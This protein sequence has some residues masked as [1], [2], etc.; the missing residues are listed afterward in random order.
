MKKTSNIPLTILPRSAPTRHTMTSSNIPVYVSKFFRMSASAR[1]QLSPI[2]ATDGR[3]CQL[4]T[5]NTRRVLVYVA[6]ITEG[7]DEMHWSQKALFEEAEKGMAGQ[8]SCLK[9][10]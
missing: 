1:T 2:N 4:D 3:V 10:Y 7:W 6:G 5:Q 8:I 9:E